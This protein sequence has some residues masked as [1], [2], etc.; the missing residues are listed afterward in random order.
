MKIF[1]KY[2][3]LYE[4]LYSIFQV[5]TYSQAPVKVSKG[6]Q[7][8]DDALA[9]SRQQPPDNL[10]CHFGFGIDTLRATP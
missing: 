5:L 6:K 8:R 9:S 7:D 4:I 10:T 3:I 2:S 1:V